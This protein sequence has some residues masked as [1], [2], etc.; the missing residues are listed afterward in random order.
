[1]KGEVAKAG[2]API[3]DLQPSTGSSADLRSVEAS[4]P[5]ESAFH[6]Q[7]VGQEGRVTAA[8]VGVYLPHGSSL[9]KENEA[10]CSRKGGKGR[11]APK[12][13]AGPRLAIKPNSKFSN[14]LCRLFSCTSCRGRRES[15]P[16]W[17]GCIQRIIEV[18]NQCVHARTHACTRI[19][20]AFARSFSLSCSF[21]R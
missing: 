17:S 10:R 4:I 11:A 2:I 12:T 7:S 18:R 9:S 21:S 13:E 5:S 16:F 6:F 1:M 19:A 15:T 20:R 3:R 14:E 8:P